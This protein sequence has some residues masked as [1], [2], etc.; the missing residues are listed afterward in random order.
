M[1]NQV[2]EVFPIE[3]SWGEGVSMEEVRIFLPPLDK[4]VRTINSKIEY[5]GRVILVTR[6][7]TADDFCMKGVWE[8]YL[9]SGKI[10]MAKR[11]LAADGHISLF[12]EV[13]VLC[14]LS[15]QTSILGQEAN[16]SIDTGTLPV[17]GPEPIYI[18]IK[19]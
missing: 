6:Y 4:G 7:I 11:L 18:L 2:L 3:P 13:K 15:P 8:L 1:S 17:S 19:E 10:P 5:R 9:V 16:I 12:R 14:E